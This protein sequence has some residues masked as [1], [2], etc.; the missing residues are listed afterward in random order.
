MMDDTNVCA[1][2]SHAPVDSHSEPA[3]LR[4]ATCGAGLH[5]PD[6]DVAA[7]GLLWTELPQMWLCPTC[8]S[9]P[10][11]WAGISVAVSDVSA[12]GSELYC[13]R[14]CGIPVMVGSREQMISEGVN[15]RSALSALVSD[16]MTAA[17]RG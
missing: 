1:S 4:C 12:H 2:G 5:G 8:S 15:L 16:A 11:V 17:R 14:C 7:R 10:D 9:R 6:A 3:T 13:L